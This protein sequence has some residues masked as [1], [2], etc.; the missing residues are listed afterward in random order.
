MNVNE[1]VSL[2]RSLTLL[3]LTTDHSV[4]CL[5]AY[6]IAGSTVELFIGIVCYRTR[7]SDIYIDPRIVPGR[8][9]NLTTLMVEPL[10]VQKLYLG[11]QE[12]SPIGEEDREGLTLIYA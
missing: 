10:R 12:L 8:A 6:I 11:R 7:I 4:S 1:L 5:V 9:S 2:Y 3:L